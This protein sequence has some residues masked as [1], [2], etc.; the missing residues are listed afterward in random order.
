M[1]FGLLLSISSKSL[2]Y[3]KNRTFTDRFIDFLNFDGKPKIGTKR[4]A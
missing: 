4:F 1:Y 2:Q 3:F